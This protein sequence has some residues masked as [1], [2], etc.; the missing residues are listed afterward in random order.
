MNK[1]RQSIINLSKEEFKQAGHLLIDQIEDFLHSIQDRP[2][3]Y[4]ETPDSF[5]KLINQGKLPENG[6]SASELLQVASELLFNHSLFNG[7]PKFLGYIT[8]SPAPIGMLGDLLADAVNS[9]CGAFILSPAA[10][11][12][13][14][15]TIQWLGE[16]IGLEGNYGGILVSGGNMAN[17]T[18]FLAGR[19]AK[20]PADTKQAGISRDA[21]MLI[22]CSAATHTWIEKA[23]VLFGLGT[24]AVRWIETDN[25]NRMNISKL[26][27]TIKQDIESGFQPIM[28]VGT[29]GDVSTGAVDDLQS[30]ASVC[31]EFNLWFHIDGA[32]GLPAAVIPSYKSLFS[33]IQEADSIAIDP[34]KWLYAPLEAGCTLVK[35]PNTLI[36]TFS[37]HP[38]YYNFDNQALEHTTNF[39]EYGL[40][41]SRGF[42][43]LKVWL[44]LQQVGRNGYVS[45]INEDIELSKRFFELAQQENELEAV[46]HS[47]SIATIRYVPVETTTDESQQEYLN[48][49]NT[50]ILNTLQQEGQAFLS[51]A[52]IQGKYCLRACIVNFRTSLADLEEI[53][54]IIIETGRKEHS[55]ASLPFTA[56]KKI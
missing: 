15:Q 10:T 12:I 7:H 14:K 48:T 18:G 36:N 29:A 1:D 52:V 43:A 24:N 53:I 33:G 21:K 45:M 38:V 50:N 55:K 46:S 27:E 5:R 11:E 25:Q 49:L 2:V 56:E 54:N 20:A 41:N 28:I 39:Y 40:Q 6:R 34:H 37:S 30:I 32:Y 31:K 42:R 26:K 51:N 44:G 13:E 4:G 16:F 22:Y 47:L 8:S 3:T 17:F 9:N 35:D 23:T 19:T